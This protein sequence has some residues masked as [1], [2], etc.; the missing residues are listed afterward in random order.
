M[1]RSSCDWVGLA[2]RVPCDASLISRLRCG[3]QRPSARMATRLDELLGAQG[4][5]VEAASPGGAA[6]SRPEW[7]GVGGGEG[8]EV[9]RRQMLAVMAAGPLAMEME[10]VRRR[11]DAVS[12]GVADERDADEWERAAAGYAR[13]VY[14]LPAVSYLPHLLADGSEI[15][16]RVSMASGGGRVR[17]LRSAALL[18]ALTAVGLGALGD[19]WSAARWWRTS[20]RV[21]GQSGDGELAAMILGKQAV[22]AMYGPGGFGDA[23]SRADAALA[24]CGGR[25]CSGAASAYKA[26]AQAYAGMGRGGEALGALADFE[27]AWGAL[28]DHDVG[29]VDSEWGQP[30][31]RM[32]FARSW[33]LTQSGDLR[34][35]GAAQDAALA[36]YPVS[37]RGRTQVEMHRAEA[38]IR[39]G[40]VEGGARHCVTVL[41]ALPGA[42]RADAL[43]ASSARAALAAVPVSQ[44]S[45]RAVREA[46]GFLALPAGRET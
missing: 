25:V 10:R 27:R 9:N 26:R 43:I 6:G 37:G 7:A 24:A 16:A 34:A 14:G 17:L 1:Q 22:L 5:L 23:L 4:A 39:A 45:I 42:W 18:G 15:S 38:L 19:H 32:R 30:E 13:Q 33:V 44:R 31:R 11:L 21:A 41:T 8:D 2:R 46:R 36:I 35:A 20:A 40:D 28:P 3:T 29:A 12:P